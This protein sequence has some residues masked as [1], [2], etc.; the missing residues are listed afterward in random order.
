MKYLRL[1]PE[2]TDFK[3][4]AIHRVA[5][6]ISAAAIVASAAAFALMGLNFGIDFR[7]G[8][9]IEVETQKPLDIGHMKGVLQPLSR[10]LG[11]IKVV[12][13][14]ERNQARISVVRQTID[15]GAVSEDE[16]PTIAEERAQTEATEKV[17]A[18]LV[19]SY[20]EKGI[21]FLQV[22]SVGGIV[23]EE[24]VSQGIWAV[25]I[26]IFMML[27]YI[28]FRFEWQ[29]SLGAVLALVHDIILTIGVFSVLQLEFN[30]SIIAALLTIVGYSMND[31]VVVYDRVRENLRKYKRLELSA[32]ID[33]SINETLSRT[34]VTSLTTLMALLSLY[35][36]GGKTVQGF[37]FAMIWGV[38]VGTYS[39]IFVAS[40]LLLLTGVKRDWSGIE[41]RPA[42][43]RAG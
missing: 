12:E 4:I 34:V 23:S 9:S 6:A 28:W 11:D 7:G 21:T 10:E 8:T 39:S 3:F 24:L 18:A 35:F 1:L 25:T 31:T 5:Y 27:V 19:E 37:T 17:K 2:R 14:G 38:I 32:L 16:D 22:E 26:A 15:P 43:V 30:L 20:G 41:N 13:Y 33:R 36:L 40:P 29:F 42:S